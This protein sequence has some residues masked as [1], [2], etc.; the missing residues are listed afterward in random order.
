M[1]RTLSPEEAVALRSRLR[2]YTIS[3]QD[4]TADWI[5]GNYPDIQYTASIHAMNMYTQAAWVGI[6]K[7]VGTAAN[8]SIV[9]NSWLARNIQVGELGAMYPDLAVIMEGDSP[10]FL[11]LIQNGLGDREHMDYGSWGGRYGL[12]NLDVGNEHYVDTV[13]R[14]VGA[15]GI[16]YKTAAASIWRWRTAY[17]N[18]F[19]SR[20]Q[21]TL[22]DDFNAV[23]H[24][25]V[26]NIN[27]STDS[28]VILFENVAVNTT[29][30]FDAS[31]TYDP[32]HPGDI[33][34]LDFEWY[35]YWDPSATGTGDSPTD[36]LSG[37]HIQALSEVNGSPTLA[38]N[39]AGFRNV[40]L[41]ESVSVTVLSLPSPWVSP[42]H[43]V[44]SVT[45]R[46]AKYPV[47]RYRRVVFNL[48]D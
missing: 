42:L 5:R 44:L 1:D 26:V 6:S 25:P 22:E 9:Q 23:G 20:M 15:D 37:L 47:T 24:A 39:A 16:A 11:Y 30:V 40:T 27:G 10:S 19:A 12:V 28:E 36:G 45:S 46:A 29:F 14:V 21:W 38:Y 34:L 13:E 2:V 32:D 18:D 43:L 33:S 35:Q 4:N 3:D 41:G 8:Y 7:D 48:A 31:E 17:Q